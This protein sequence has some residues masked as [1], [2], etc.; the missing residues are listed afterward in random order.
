MSDKE[1]P[2]SVSLRHKILFL[3]KTPKEELIE[4]GKK[5]FSKGMLFDALEY[6]EKAQDEKLLLEIKQKSLEEADIVLYQNVCRALKLEMKEDELIRLKE[7]A[8][9]MGKESVAQ[10]ASLY[11]ISKEKK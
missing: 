9:K 10:S 11:M 1:V 4:I 2:L 7:C 8:E 5:Y 3:E 6:F